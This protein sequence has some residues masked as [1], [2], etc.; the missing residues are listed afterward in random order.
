M[1]LIM[2]IMF[3]ALAIGLY[4]KKMNAVS[5][6]ILIAIIAATIGWYAIHH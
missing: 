4:F 3:F 5:W 6:M 2:P 1:S